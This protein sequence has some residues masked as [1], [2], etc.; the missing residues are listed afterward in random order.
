MHIFYII[1]FK[2]RTKGMNMHKKNTETFLKK[3]KTKSVDMLTN[4]KEIF[5]KSFNSLW[6]YKLFEGANH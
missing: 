4:D 2:K 1:I 6:K 5:L 3:K